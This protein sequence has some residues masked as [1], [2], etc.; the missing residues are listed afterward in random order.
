LSNAKNKTYQIHQE[1]RDFFTALFYI[2]NNLDN[3]KRLYLDA[4]SVIWS[5]DYQ[6]VGKDVINS[7]IGSVEAIKIEVFFRKIS[8]EKKERSDMLTNNL[9]KE[10]GKLEMWFT[11]DSLHLPL[12]TRYNKKPFPVLWLLR[13]YE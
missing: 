12:K 4:S 8:P 3:P 11:N 2:R 1:T 7:C 6:V 9:L 13:S 10:D 5:C